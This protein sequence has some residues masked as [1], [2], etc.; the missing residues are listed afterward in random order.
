M[1][2]ICVRGLPDEAKVLLRL[3]AARNGRSMEA[4]LR[5]ILICALLR[6]GPAAGPPMDRP[7]AG[8]PMD[9]PAAGPPMDRPAADGYLDGPEPDTRA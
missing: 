3:R 7:A 9:R 2:A 4:E 5:H 6:D 8:P 1:A